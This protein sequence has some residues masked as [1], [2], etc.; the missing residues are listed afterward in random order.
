MFKDQTSG[1]IVF[2]A[3]DPMRAIQKGHDFRSLLNPCL[4]IYFHFSIIPY[5]KGG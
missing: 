1:M 5:H 4:H 2:S 3:T